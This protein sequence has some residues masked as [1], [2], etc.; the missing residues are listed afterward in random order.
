MTGD[1]I[2]AISLVVSFGAFCAFLIW[3]VSAVA[4]AME[5]Q[6]GEMFVEPPNEPPTWSIRNIRE[7]ARSV[8]KMRLM[9]G[10]ARRR[11][12]AMRPGRYC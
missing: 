3:R 10:Q 8:R 7:A 9:E 2:T 6:S 4:M 1:Q 11:Y 12:A 5:R